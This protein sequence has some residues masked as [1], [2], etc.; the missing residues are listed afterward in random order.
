MSVKAARFATTANESHSRALQRGREAHDVTIK[1]RKIATAR[2]QAPNG[3]RFTG[4]DRAPRPW[5]L[6]HSK[7]RFASGATAELDV[8]AEEGATDRVTARRM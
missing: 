6:E 2:I 3:L 5:L 7:Q 8:H 4:A 1:A